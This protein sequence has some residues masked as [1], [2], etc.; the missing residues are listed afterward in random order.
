MDYH[1]RKSMINKEFKDIETNGSLSVVKQCEF[2]EINRSGI[3]YTPK[4]VAFKYDGKLIKAVEGIYNDICF[5]GH[6]KVHLEL[7]DLGFKIGLKTVRNIRKKLGI[8]AITVKPK[9]TIPRKEH[10]KHS[11]K[12]A[13][14]KITRPN[15]VWAT[16]ISVPQKAA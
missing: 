5:Y 6:T 4:T 14:L 7:L 1:S 11:Y 9:T 2:L 12:L 10:E 13:G 3:Y 8:K 15:Q 16:D